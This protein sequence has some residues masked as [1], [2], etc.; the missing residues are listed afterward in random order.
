MVN[1]SVQRDDLT[2][3]FGNTPETINSDAPA[4]LSFPPSY[5]NYMNPDIGLETNIDIAEL[6]F[7]MLK[8]KCLDEAE[9]AYNL[10]HDIEG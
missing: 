4:A 1:P 6:T 10:D 5:V 3:P 7:K 9:E 2:S 8:D